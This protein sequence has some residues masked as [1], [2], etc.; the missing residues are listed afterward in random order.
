[1]S[2]ILE[3]I[4]QPMFD[5]I[6]SGQYKLEDLTMDVGTYRTVFSI[7]LQ[8]TMASK[9]DKHTKNPERN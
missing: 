6:M 3:R 5:D 2:K 9:L 7:A 8:P 4:V 1:M